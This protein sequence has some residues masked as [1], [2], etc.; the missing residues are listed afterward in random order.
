MGRLQRRAQQK[1]MD[2]REMSES[3]SN[4]AASKRGAGYAKEEDMT[5]ARAYIFVSTD[6]ITGAEQKAA[7]F[8]SRIYNGCVERKPNNCAA[9][10]LGSIKTR[11]KLIIKA[12]TR[13]SACFNS[14]KAV[15]KRG[16]CEEDILRF[17]T[18][19][20]KKVKVENPLEDVGKAFQFKE[21]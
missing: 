2:Y 1:S 7:T 19:L 11:C 3:N 13:F 12:C 6:L 4:I 8:Y 5:I 10:T 9:R 20:Y 18:A 14:I 21:C 16:V 15:K 17:T